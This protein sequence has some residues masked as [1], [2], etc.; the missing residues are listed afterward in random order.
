MTKVFQDWDNPEIRVPILSDAFNYCD[1]SRNNGSTGQTHSM[2]T[3]NPGRM[4]E[5][6]LENLHRGLPPL[7][8]VEQ[9][10][11]ETCH[12]RNM[13]CSSRIITWLHRKTNAVGQPLFS[14]RCSKGLKHMAPE[15]L[16][17]QSDRRCICCSIVRAFAFLL[18]PAIRILVVICPCEEIQAADKLTI[19]IDSG[20][21]YQTI[22]GFGASDAWRCQ[23]VGKN[24]PL[25]K[26]ERIADLLFS[27]ET[28]AQG[29]PRGI[30]L[31][32][33]RFY[34][35]AGTAEQGD[36]SDI[37]NPWRRGECFQNAD[38]TYDWAK[39]AGQQWFLRAARDR[40]VERF[41]AFPNAPPVHLS[42][43]GKGYATKGT[44]I[45]TSSRAAWMI[46]Q[47]TWWRSWIISRNKV[48]LLII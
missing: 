35:S 32:I 36:D 21:T 25:E 28:D 40:G 4:D 23:F 1:I 22:D 20:S 8:T 10:E 38:G 11:L 6:S 34:L 19:H 26:R 43:N 7:I 12:S 15:D 30:G 45:S 46:M 29:N 41:L 37:G 3:G 16:D 44:S 5:V 9:R 42:K 13:F 24:W 33:W 39:L 48:C 27:R 47:T 2:E 31:S 18:I 14:L 17:A